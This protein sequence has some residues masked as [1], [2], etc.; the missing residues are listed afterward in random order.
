MLHFFCVEIVCVTDQITI[1]YPNSCPNLCGRCKSIAPESLAPLAD[2]RAFGARARFSSRLRRS[3]FLGQLPRIESFA[4]TSFEIKKKKKIDLP[5]LLI[6]K[7]K[8]QTNLFLS[9]FLGGG[10]LMSGLWQ[11]GWLAPFLTLACNRLH[12]LLHLDHII[13]TEK[14]WGNHHFARGNAIL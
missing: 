2:S 12:G 9:F 14:F 3:F 5:S 4:K 1:T 10:G 13:Y 6:F 8:G 7:P 11:T